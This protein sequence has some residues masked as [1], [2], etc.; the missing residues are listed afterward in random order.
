MP[1]SFPKNQILVRK[2]VKNNGIYLAMAFDGHRLLRRILNGFSEFA[3]SASLL[4]LELAR[5]LKNQ[6]SLR[7]KQ[8]VIA[9][10]VFWKKKDGVDIGVPEWRNKARLMI[11]AWHELVKDLKKN[12]MSDAPWNNYM[13]RKNKF[14]PND[15][16]TQ[17][18]ES[19]I[20]M[21]EDPFYKTSFE[22]MQYSM[23]IYHPQHVRKALVSFG[24]EPRQHHAIIHKKR[25]KEEEMILTS[26]GYLSNA[27]VESRTALGGDS[28]WHY[29]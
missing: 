24:M 20:S 19:R 29:D 5:L 23:S 7:R 18:V 15:A 6:I 2:F 14:M 22:N 21:S 27:F 26:S 1:T 9:N 17:M 8:R 3:F 4:S 10:E 25:T 28:Y 16:Q 12:D 13:R 11:W